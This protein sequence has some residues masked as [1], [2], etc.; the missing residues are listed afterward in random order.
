M[1][2]RQS[3][4]G[5]HRILH[6]SGDV[7]GGESACAEL[8]RLGRQCLAESPQLAINLRHATFIDSQ[9]LGLFVELL[10]AAQAAGGDLV[11]VE[12]ND[13]ARKWFALSGL[14]HIFRILPDEAALSGA[15][16]ARPAAAAKAGAALEKVN[17]E[18]MVQELEA[19]LGEATAGGEPS[20]VGP[21]DEK[22]LSE[23][24]KLLAGG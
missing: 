5:K 7:R 16:A 4:A 19:A 15:P 14:E 21:I 11:I 8:H 10:R 23:I 3:T 13:R 20:V 6:V 12:L 22:A 1:P 9:T 2:I 17:V 18:R 24:E